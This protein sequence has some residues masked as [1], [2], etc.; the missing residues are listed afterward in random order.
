MIIV[1]LTLLKVA[2]DNR[3]FP[4]SAEKSSVSHQPFAGYRSR[5]A[6]QSNPLVLLLDGQRP[7]DFWRWNT[8]RPYFLFLAYLI[9]GL[10]C[11]Q[12][13]LPFIAHSGFYITLIGYTGL[14]IEATLPL[15]QIYKNWSAK[16]CRG[17]RLSVIVNWLL[18]DAMKMGYFF[19]SSEPVPWP[20]KACGL[21][22]A[23][24]DAFLGLQF[25]VYGSGV[26]TGRG[27]E[28]GEKGV[29]G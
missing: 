6:S 7:Y 19:G 27:L 17:F 20:F 26:G 10:A 25:W 8:S 28:M 2:L 23:G 5:S 22:Q 21:F 15:P 29:L 24:C 3:S 1:Q 12:I 18:G 9:G 14:A 11:I 4:A 13:F 16:S